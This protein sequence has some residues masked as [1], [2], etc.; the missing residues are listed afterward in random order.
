[1]TAGL[2]EIALKSHPEKTCQIVVGKKE[3]REKTKK[4]MLEKNPTFIQG[5]KTRLSTEDKL[6]GIFI[7]EGTLD[8]II[9]YNLK[10]KKEKCE[11]SARIIRNF[12]QDPVIKRIGVV[13]TAA[14][15]YQAIII[16]Q[17]MYGLSSFPN[18]TK[19]HY[20][21]INS[22]ETSCQ[23]IILGLPS[24]G[25]NTA[26]MTEELGNIPMQQWY[27]CLRLKYFRS[28]W[29]VKRS[30]KFYRQLLH[31]FDQKFGSHNNKS[32]KQSNM[33]EEITKLCQK[34]SIDDLV[35]NDVEPD[36]ISKKNAKISVKENYV[37]RS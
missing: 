17:F 19:K 26:A 6:L 29:W 37:Q 5:T 24:R 36:I 28:K 8:E 13:K 15:L 10:K 7:I 9:M 16:P 4:E 1:M 20:Q 12:L 2:D 27:E 32:P 21:V 22:T 23:S 30:G 3:F 33:L 35:L 25:T 31:E 34:Y 14:M 18:M 11:N